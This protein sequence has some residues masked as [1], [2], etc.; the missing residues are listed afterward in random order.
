LEDTLPSPDFPSVLKLVFWALVALDVAGIGL[1]FLLGLA[2]AGSARSNPIQ[3][4]L[5]LLVLPA[6]PLV[7]SILLYTR[8]SSPGLRMVALL[9]AAAPLLIAVAGRAY[10]TATMQAS[11]NESGE[12][13]WYRA[14]PERELAEAILRDD[15]SRAI[16]LAP[17]ANVNARG[18]ADMTLLILSLRRLP[19]APAPQT[20][21]VRA[22]LAA[23]AVPDAPGQDEYPL[24]VA[25]SAS[26]K[27][28]TAAMTM[29]LDAGADVNQVD[30][31]GKPV[32]FAGTF[33][34][35]SPEALPL[36]LDRGAH[37]DTE[38]RHGETALISAAVTRNWGAALVLLERG[39]DWR[40]GKNASGSTFSQIVDGDAGQDDPGGV[41]AQVKQFLATH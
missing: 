20:A 7:A 21:I 18:A 29:L 30:S 1:L 9:V 11:M 41:R 36:L 25:V 26:G 28:G 4:A 13:T 19:H 12:M 40:R 37:I 38:T 6:I 33:R 3:V 5:A 8:T 35:A 15:S 16:A 10:A 2:A 24:A 32:W 17:A 31:F 23:K 27:A 34:A 22:L 14:G 39:A